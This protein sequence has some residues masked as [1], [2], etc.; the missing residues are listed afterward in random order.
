MSTIDL[1]SVKRGFGDAPTES[2][3]IFRQL[4]DAMAEPGKP[5]DVSAAPEPPQGISK[6]VGA[7]ALTLFDFETNVWLCESLRG[8]EVEAWLRFHCNSPLVLDPKE[9]QFAVISLDGPY[10]PLS[11]F[12]Q[13]DAKYPDLS[14]TVLLQVE[15]FTGGDTQTLSGP[16]IPDTRE[17]SPAG[18][19][20]GFWQDVKENSGLFQFGVDMF[21]CGDDSVAGLPR[22]T[23]LLQQGE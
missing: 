5:V 2:Q 22:S 6:A 11:E 20:S 9:A 16:G 1:A 18:L 13:G 19:P 8:G 17:F 23:Q 7:V 3:Y 10:L 15:S 4:M 12:H 14:T 21:L